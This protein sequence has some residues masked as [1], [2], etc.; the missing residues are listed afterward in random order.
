MLPTMELTSYIFNGSGLNDAENVDLALVRGETYT[1]NINANGH[2]FLIKSIQG[3]TSANAY[4]NGVTNNGT[5]SGTITF[6]VPMNAPAELFYNCQFHSSM[7]GK[8]TITG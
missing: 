8:F 3:N 6:T 5:Q 2:P 4:N 7:T 1:F